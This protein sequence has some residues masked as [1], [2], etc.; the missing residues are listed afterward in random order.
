M[1]SGFSRTVAQ[2][3]GPSVVSMAY[4]G[5][6][7]PC[8]RRKLRLSTCCSRSQAPALQRQ[9]AKPLPL[10]AT[11][12][13]AAVRREQLT[14][15]LGGRQP[16][17]HDEHVGVVPLAGAGGGGGVGAQRR[18]HARHLV[19]GD[20]RARPRP[21]EQD[22]R[23]DV[24]LGDQLADA[25]PD[26]GPLDGLAT[27]RADEHDV[28][29]ALL[30][31]VP[32]RVGQGRPLVRPER[33]LHAHQG[34]ARRARQ[35]ALDRREFLRRTAQLGGAVAL[36]GPALAANARVAL[37]ADDF[38]SM[39]DDPAKESPIDTVV[40][41]MMEN[42]SFDHYFGWLADDKK[43]RERGKRAGCGGNVSTLRH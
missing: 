12:G 28:V 34:T 31:L 6:G 2:P 33:C 22:A 5:I 4:V 37:A 16:K 39:L 21:A 40:V 41:V 20:R 18:A 29:A 3:S 1:R 10:R 9:T 24:T 26:L 36:G 23:L 17:P 25:L 11:V 19:R 7:L 14:G 27:R 38:G 13:E 32:D 42:R 43:Y 35:A 15:D 30:Q 8:R